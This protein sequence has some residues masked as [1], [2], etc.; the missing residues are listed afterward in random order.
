M[1]PDELVLA[2]LKAMPHKKIDG[3]KRLQKLAYLMASAGV[4]CNIQFDLRDY[5]PFSVEIA[6]AADYLTFSGLIEEDEQQ[7]GDN[8][9]F[10]TS[11]KLIES[12]PTRP[13]LSHDHVKALAAL[14][15]YTTIQL[16]VAA[17]Y[18]FF[19]NRG[20]DEETARQRTVAMKPAKASPAVLAKA[21]EILGHLPH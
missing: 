3:K 11:Y 7:L 4:D 6:Q 20:L 18:L 2:L 9:F 12:I 15:K 19:R 14:A 8:N 13:E 10:M 5:G 1:A 17:T 21:P 16:E